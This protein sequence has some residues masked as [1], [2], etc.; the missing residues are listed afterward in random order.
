MEAQPAQQP[1]STTYTRPQQ[2]ADAYAATLPVETLTRIFELAKEG[3]Q[4]PFDRQNMRWSFQEISCQW[5]I[6]VGKQRDYAVGYERQAEALG[7]ALRSSGREDEVRSLALSQKL[8]GGSQ[9][10]TVELLKL[11]SALKKLELIRVGRFYSAY[12]DE[13]ALE[14]MSKLKEVQEVVF[15]GAPEALTL[16][17]VLHAWPVLRSLRLSCRFRNETSMLD[18]M[19]S[20]A[21]QHLDIVPDLDMIRE[22][23][24]YIKD[25][26]LPRSL[27]VRDYQ[28]CFRRL[29]DPKVAEAL[30]PLASRLHRFSAPDPWQPSP[31]FDH[32][33]SS[34]SS[35]RQLEIG[36]SGTQPLPDVDGGG[37]GHNLPPAA[38]L[39]NLTSLQELVLRQTLFVQDAAQLAPTLVEILDAPPSSFKR[40]EVH[41]SLFYGSEGGE[42]ARAEIAAKAE[43]AG[44]RLLI[45]RS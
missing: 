8:M 9:G 25:S 26:D 44:I 40:I 1:T 28:G 20:V 32:F 24:L 31:A 21:L 37:T 36:Y 4:D 16:S 38:A 39:R 41:L 5:S 11:C 22:L 3:V 42:E 10:A 13:E 33:I 7:N 6:A 27:T 17:R 23:L 15:M 29:L 12:G 14:A 34:M 43:A 35:L 19:P 45:R 18:P 2:P 30:L